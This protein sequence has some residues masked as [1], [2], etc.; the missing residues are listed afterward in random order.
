M[1]S[2]R[3]DEIFRVSSDGGTPLAVSREVYLNQF[4]GAPS[5][6]GTKVA[7]MAKGISNIQWWRNGHSHID[8]TELWLKPVAEGAPYTQVLAASAKHAFPMWRPDGGALYYMGDESGAENIWMTPLGGGAPVQITHFTDGRVLW[9]SIGYDGRSIVFERGFG[10]WRLDLASGQAAPVQIALRG[11]P[12]SE[13]VRHLNLSA[14]KGLALSPDGKKIAVVGHGQV[15]A[16]PSKDPRLGP[17]DQPQYRLQFGAGLVA[18]FPPSGL[19]VRTWPR[20]PAGAVRFRH[21][22]GGRADAGQGR[23][24]CAGLCPRRQVHRL[25]E[26]RHRTA[27]AGP[28]PRWR[29]PG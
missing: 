20:H 12:A 8:E 26:R 27:R 4:Q 17:A 19:C 25:C 1:A 13:G 23:G 7:L 28:R 16:G 29:G 2:G 9:P 24:L 3:E 21:R 6:D 18:G 5:P 22:Q 15:F 10:I 14:F 11:A